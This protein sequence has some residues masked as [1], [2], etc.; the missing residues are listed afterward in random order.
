MLI[1]E[2]FLFITEFVGKINDAIT[3]KIFSERL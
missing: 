1:A 3:D 2:L